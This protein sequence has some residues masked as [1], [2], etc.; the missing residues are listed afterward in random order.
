M[1]HA[2]PN[3]EFSEAGSVQEALA[4]AE[5]V[6]PD[7]AFIDTDV[8]G[9]PQGGI[10]VLRRMRS[11]EWRAEAVIVSSS[12]SFATA[13][14]SLRL[15]AQDYVLKDSLCPELLTDLVEVLRERFATTSARPCSP[16][17]RAGQAFGAARAA[18]TMLVGSSDAMAAVRRRIARVADSDAPVLIRG[19]TGTGKE[20]VAKALHEASSRRDEPF[21]AMNCSTLPGALVESLL[22]GHEKGAFTGADRRRRGQFEL[23]GGGTLLLDEIAEMP[24]ELQSKL[25]R[26]LEERRFRPVGSEIELPARA[27]ILAATHADLAQRVKDGR[28][29]EDLFYRLDVVTIPLPAL[30]D[31]GHDLLELLA[32]FTALSR[33]KLRFTDEAVA[34]LVGRAWPGNV[35][36]LRNLVERLVLLAE[37]DLIDAPVLKELGGFAGKR[38]V[39]FLTAVEQFADWLLSQ[40]GVAGSRL[41]LVEQAI[42]DRAVDACDGNKAAAA[43]LVGVDRKIV[44]RRCAPRAPGTATVSSIRR[45]VQP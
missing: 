40:P 4:T 1:L 23:A 41:D 39:D 22:F 27:R 5:V 33:R 34:W 6:R 20:L 7:L 8:P 13:R 44:D 38:E 18:P 36:E 30:V 10:E 12:E 35:R 16:S 45:L 15:G 43:R 14:D 11:A 21:V 3:A 9:H 19:E 32:A 29:R 28:F 24:L 26:V 31:R 17:Q 2:V 42:I 25:L 37:D